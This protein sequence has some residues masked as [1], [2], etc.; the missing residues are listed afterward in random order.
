[1][2]D[3]R[4]RLFLG[5]AGLGALPGWMSAL[6]DVPRRAVLVPTAANPLAD[7]PFV[8]RAVEVLESA[9]SRVGVLDLEC[10]RAT[11]VERA[12]REAEL[13]FVTGGYAMFLLEHVR[14]TGFDQIVS[15]AVRGGSLSYA[16]ISAGAAL[17]GPDLE[18]LRDADDPGTVASSR[19]LGL[20]PFVVLAHRD[21]GRAARHDR[22]AAEHG[23]PSRFV[24]LSDD[25]A[26]AVTGT[27]WELLSSP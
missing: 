10:A 9:G 6:P 4:Q 21:R 12:L 8:L 20:V 1:M 22:L 27:A 17:A 7:A 3:S 11:Q 2:I 19:G 26:V 5:S 18:H 16:G 25:Q 23:D 14:R 15:D 13:V 24:S